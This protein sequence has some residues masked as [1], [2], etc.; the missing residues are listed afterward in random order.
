M[1][2]KIYKK[3]KK[4]NGETFARTLRDHHNGL[5]EIEGIINIV[6]HAG[7]NA[8]PLLPYLMSLLASND[9]SDSARA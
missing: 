9:D 4:Q 7:R 6:K 1:S 5:L 8:A 3:I 2:D